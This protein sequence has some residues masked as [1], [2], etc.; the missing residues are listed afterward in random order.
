MP[1][2]HRWPT[3]RDA[4]S[5]ARPLAAVLAAAIV[6]CAQSP[7]PTPPVARAPV[8]EALP[9]VEIRPLGVV[10]GDWAIVLRSA[11]GY[12]AADEGELW[13][14]PLAGGEARRVISWT[15]SG[16]GAADYLRL[17]LTI[18]ARQLAPDRHRIVLPYAKNGRAT[19]GGGLAIIDLFSGQ[20]AA[21]GTPNIQWPT[22]P[23]WSPD[24]KRIAFDTYGST[25]WQGIS[26]INADDTDLRTVCTAEG[27]TDSRGM[28]AFRGCYGVDGWTP[29]SKRIRFYEVDGYSLIDADT[30]AITRYGVHGASLISADWYGTTSMV[31]LGAVDGSEQQLLTFDRPDS[32]PRTID[33][34][35]RGALGFFEPRWSPGT[36]N[37]LYR[38]GGELFVYGS[39]GPGRR[40]VAAQCEVRGEW[41]PSGIDVVYLAPCQG[42][43][44]LRVAATIGDANRLVWSPPPGPRSDFRVVDLAVVRYP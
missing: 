30:K 28:G 11:S 16:I 17:G 12:G 41:H 19:F 38:R 44:E 39:L 31:A 20:F 15:A 40:V 8:P 9:D 13:A 7:E 34:A 6:A 43:G 10:H 1:L 26:V 14:V 25:F 4:R 27:F 24:G 18:V 35:P 29:D 42:T 23:A 32:P 3:L 21:L 5:L 33:R 2:T 22:R 37:L 36:E